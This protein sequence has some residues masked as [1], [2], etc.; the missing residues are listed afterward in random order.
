MKML[1]DEFL[2]QYD[3]AKRYQIDIQASVEAV[4]PTVRQLDFGNSALIR[5]L[6]KFR[7]LP[8]DCSNLEGLKKTGFVI[9]AEEPP[10]EM[11]LGLVGRFW[12]LAGD[13]QNIEVQ[14]FQAFNRPGYAKA[15]WNFSLQPADEN[16]T[17]LSTETRI[18]CTDKISLRKFRFYWYFIGPFSGFIRKEILK[19][20]KRKVE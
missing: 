17:R 11:V 15:V 6:F 5:W 18:C 1:I 7:G 4:Y 12:R 8:Q 14:E 2:S 20:I 9:L 13:I 3:V 19:A 10:R 16:I